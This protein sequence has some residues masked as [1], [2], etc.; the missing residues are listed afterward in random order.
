MKS[1][2]SWDNHALLN[3]ED[4]EIVSVCVEVPRTKNVFQSP[5]AAALDARTDNVA[6]PR[7]LGVVVHSVHDRAK[8]VK[9]RLRTVV[10]RPALVTTN[11]RSLSAAD[12]A[13]QMI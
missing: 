10:G 5:L 7:N 2:V 13:R 1:H 11:E 8:L 6:L 4:A 9:V 12:R 3:C